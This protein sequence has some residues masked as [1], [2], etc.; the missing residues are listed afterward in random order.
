[1][2]II[3]KLTSILKRKRKVFGIGKNK[4]KIVKLPTKLP[5]KIFFKE[6]FLLRVLLT[7]NKSKKSKNKLSKKTKSR[8]MVITFHPFY[9][10]KE[11]EKKL[12]I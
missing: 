2:T 3:K 10:K 11:K 4:S 8:Y 12:S 9:Y 6:A 7:V 5:K 1:M